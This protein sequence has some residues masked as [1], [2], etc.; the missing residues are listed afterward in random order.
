MK[1]NTILLAAIVIF[2]AVGI[3]YWFSQSDTPE[4]GQAI[5]ISET[6]KPEA[7][8]TVTDDPKS[9]FNLV[10][11]LTNFSLTPEKVGT[12]NVDNEG[13]LVLLVD[14]EEVTRLYTTNYHI[15]YLEPGEREISVSFYGNNYGVYEVDGETLSVSTKYTVSGEVENDSSMDSMSEDEMS[16]S[17][18]HDAMGNDHT[19]PDHDHDTHDH[20]S[21]HESLEI[22]SEVV[23]SV[24]VLVMEDALSG[25]NVHLSTENFNFAPENASLEHSESE[26]HAHIYVDGEKLSR[27]YGNWFY[28]PE[29][30]IG[31]HEIRVTL[32]S[33]NHSDLTKDGEVIEAVDIVEVN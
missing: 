5:E 31:A 23:P 6:T 30:E 20:S 12:D 2:A 19:D 15:G 11:D 29:L 24:G 13:Y 17:M 1:N 7:V 18:T 32:N 8:L 14:G 10:V 21:T 27:V 3:L 33:N 25:W 4:R 26:G 22:T 9:G 16:D 28:I